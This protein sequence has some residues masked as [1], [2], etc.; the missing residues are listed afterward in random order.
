MRPVYRDRILA[1]RALHP[2]WTQR[3]IADAVGCHIRTV[4]Y[5]LSEKARANERKR[6]KLYRS[7]PEIAA[8]RTERSRKW[9]ED[10]PEVI[11]KMWRESYYRR[12]GL[13]VPDTPPRA[14]GTSR[15]PQ[16]PVPRPAPSLQAA[17]PTPA[18]VAALQARVLATIGYR[19]TSAAS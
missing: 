1:L 9:A 17:P 5:N 12:R 8:A 10:N 4:H 14:Y 16:S 13:P 3:Q 7:R 15:P 19:G 18:E 2:D 11:R 6:Q